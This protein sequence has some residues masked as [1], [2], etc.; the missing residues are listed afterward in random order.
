MRA[1]K[2]LLWLCAG[3]TLAAATLALAAPD[4]AQGV[5][6]QLTNAEALRGKFE[7]I[8][9]VAGFAKPLTSL[10]TFLVVRDKG[11]IWSTEKPFASTLRLTRDQI[12]A[13]Q[14]GAVAFR[15]DA[16]SEPTVRVIN[17]VLFSLLNGDVSALN[18]HFDVAGDIKNANWHL[19]LTPKD[20]G[21][22]KIMQRIEMRGDAFVKQIVISEANG[23]VTTINL[24]G[25]A[26]TPALSPTEA[27]SF[28]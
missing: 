17:G 16:Q 19:T 22:A 13:T 10:G 24:S 27:A 14:G 2:A 7:Q 26:T 8:K 9:Q 3:L 23:D 1:R 28:D 6:A 25:Q 20:A 21:V 4:L 18:T 12:L 11:V 5:R 15:L